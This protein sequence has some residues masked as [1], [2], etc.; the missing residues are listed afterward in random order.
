[1]LEGGSPMPVKYR[2]NKVGLVVFI[3]LLASALVDLGLVVFGGVNGS[4]SAFMVGV[5]GIKAPWVYF[6]IGTILGHLAFPMCQVTENQSPP[7][8]SPPS[9]LA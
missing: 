8:N 7:D 1:M 6:V 9:P 3:L 2:M 5:V 4:I